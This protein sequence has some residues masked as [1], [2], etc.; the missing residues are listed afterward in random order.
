MIVWIWLSCAKT[1]PVTESQEPIVAGPR[2]VLDQPEGA[3]ESGEGLSIGKDEVVAY[4]QEVRVA[5]MPRFRTCVADA[6]DADDP[7]LVELIVER[8]GKTRD[9]VVS[10][11]S[12]NPAV[13]DCAR[14]VMAE[15][16][17]PPPPAS[18]LDAN[19]VLELPTFAFSAP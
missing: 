4:V 19:G 6:G 8:S 16:S 13:D 17:L 5:V 3:G 14:K 9:V 7:T 10:R 1:V 2:V 11:S 18:R 12:G 15:T